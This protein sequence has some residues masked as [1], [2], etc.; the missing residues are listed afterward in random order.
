MHYRDFHAAIKELI[1]RKELR[2]EITYRFAEM[3]NHNGGEKYDA[4]Q[5]MNEL[6]LPNRSDIF[7]NNEFR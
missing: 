1:E 7:G 2:Y 3:R 4:L 5:A 6:T